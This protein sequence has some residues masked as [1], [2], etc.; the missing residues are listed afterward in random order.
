VH[1]QPQMH[2]LVTQRVAAVATAAAC[3]AGLLITVTGSAG[4]SPAP[5]I[6][7]VQHQLSKLESASERLDQQYDG[8]LGQ[9]TLTDQR[10]ALVNRQIG[11]SSAQF[12]SM[13]SQITRI[14]I[15]AY[16]DGNVTSSLALLTSGNPQ[17]ILDESSILLELSASDNA[18]IS[19]FLSAARQLE[20]AQLVARRT[21]A[22]VLQLK[23]NLA[24]RKAA[25]Q[26]LVNQQEALLAQLTPAE[27][28]G[29]GPG[30]GSSKP[31]KYT[32]PTTSQADKAVKF[33]YAQLGCPYVYGG[34]GPCLQGFDCSGLTMQA[35]A[36]A[37]VS[38]PRTSYDQWA[39]L[40][41][42]SLSDVQPGDILVFFG[43]GHV[44]LYV[45][46]NEFIQAPQPGQDVQLVAFEGANTPGID[47]A[48]RP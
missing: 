18:Q 40:P 3:V 44:A 9:L 47:G 2:K 23:R 4:A 30:G 48:V 31:V 32:G 35:W 29:T 15:T 20:G 8:V 6:A 10:L 7:Q 13:R 25:L 41:H 19:Q 11:S 36:S 37:G 5:T 27:Q 43:A 38:I 46:H 33:A 1:T 45:G 17:E 34:T 42:V 26:K 14:A 21:R 12:N 39:S 28:V 22:G 16:E 24:G